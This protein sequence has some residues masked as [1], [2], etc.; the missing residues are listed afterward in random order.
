[1]LEKKVTNKDIVE[2]IDAVNYELQAAF[3]VL[4]SV[5]RIVENP[6]HARFHLEFSYWVGV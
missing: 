5:D 2:L 4:Q 3:K 1:M 6:E